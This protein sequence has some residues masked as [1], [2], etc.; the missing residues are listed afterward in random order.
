MPRRKFSDT[1]H[2]I[3]VQ[4]PESVLAP[5]DLLLLDPVKGKVKFG[6][7]SALITRLLREYLAAREYGE[8]NMRLYCV[9]SSS[10]GTQVVR[11]GS[12]ASAV[13]D[14]TLANITH[15]LPFP[16]KGGPLFTMKEYKD[17]V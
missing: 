10:A 12:S 17:Y 1:R 14:C 15:C 5:I 9:H 2:Q 7:R 4:L 3:T 8:R 13:E 16:E 6:A 11:A